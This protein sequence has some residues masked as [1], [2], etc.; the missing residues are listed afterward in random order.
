MLAQAIIIGGGGG[1]AAAAAAGPTTG[2]SA[3]EGG[4]GSGARPTIRLQTIRD[5]VHLLSDVQYRC[6]L[7]M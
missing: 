4:G 7:N 1:A 6:E 5:V 2:K 3:A